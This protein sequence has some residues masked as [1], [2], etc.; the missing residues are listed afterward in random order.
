MKCYYLGSLKRIAY[1]T[2]GSLWHGE[3]ISDNTDIIVILKSIIARYQCIEL[4]NEQGQET[5][6]YETVRR[7]Q[8]TFKL[9]G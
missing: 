2:W 6:Y 7:N 8:K 4:Y 3:F 9:E 1:L 5:H